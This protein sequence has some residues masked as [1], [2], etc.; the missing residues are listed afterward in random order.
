[1]DD[2]EYRRTPCKHFV[3][4]D[5]WR[6]DKDN[7]ACT[8]NPPGSARMR[9]RNDL[10][11]RGPKCIGDSVAQRW[12]FAE[13]SP[14]LRANRAAP[15]ATSRASSPLAQRLDHGK[16]LFMRNNAPSFKVGQ[17]F[18]NRVDVV[19]LESEQVL[20]RLGHQFV[21]PLTGMSRQYV[22]RH[23]LRGFEFNLQKLPHKYHLPPCPLLEQA[24]TLA[25]GAS[26]TSLINLRF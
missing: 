25:F 7:L 8:L 14:A 17:S 2:G 11:A 16:H 21:A 3:S 6:P 20:D 9:H 4:Q 5:E 22:Q 23:N 19:L 24:E 13:Q 15:A 10:I 26:P 1:M 12:L 18:S